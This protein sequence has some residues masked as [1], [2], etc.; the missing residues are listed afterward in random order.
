VWR[1]W[2][3]TDRYATAEQVLLSAMPD[4]L[5]DDPDGLR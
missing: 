4:V 5:A 1:L 2:V 3:G